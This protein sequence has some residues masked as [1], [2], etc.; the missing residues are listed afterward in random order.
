VKSI[1]VAFHCASN[2]GYAI[3]S[4]EQLFYNMALNLCADDA[5]RIHFAYPSMLSGPSPTV[6]ENFNQY[7]IVDMASASAADHV[8]AAAYVHKHDID[9]LFGFDQPVSRPIYKHL[10]SAGIR[11]F[12]SYWGAPMS[13]ANG[14][15]RRTVKQMEVALRRHGP[16]DYIFESYGMAQTAILGRGIR[17]RRTSVIYLG[18]DAVRFR[19]DVADARYVYEQLPV[20]AGRRIFIYTGHMEPR[21]GIAVIMSA[22]NRI[23]ARRTADDWQIAL[24]GNKNGEELP[25]LRMLTAQTRPHVI[26]GGYRADLPLL[27]RGCY[28]GIIASTGW[29]SLTMS[30]M[31]MQSS[32]LPLLISDLPGL[33]ETIEHKV[34][35]WLL[36]AGDVDA[37]AN[38]M[39]RLLADPRCR[40][41]LSAQARARVETAFTSEIQLQKLTQLVRR[42]AA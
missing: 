36:P 37:L 30:S 31:E 3:G 29:D 33:R 7:L 10:R 20:P 6:P 1:L 24:F 2:T 5:S 13:S 8:R 27:H 21:K 9:T 14:L 4:L 26:F 15:L 41:A 19:P 38:A 40:D 34:T 25:Y 32:G 16:D 35:G 12:V 28:A 23:A 39:E 22:A 18:T 11:H 17:A 42:L